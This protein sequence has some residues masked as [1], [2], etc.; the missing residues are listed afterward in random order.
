MGGTVA[1]AVMFLA[2]TVWAVEIMIGRK[3][4]KSE[5]TEKVAWAMGDFG[6]PA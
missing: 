2:G 3:N 4:R 1:V 6:N 5:W